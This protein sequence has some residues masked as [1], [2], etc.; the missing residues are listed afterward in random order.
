VTSYTFGDSAIAS[1]RLRIVAAV[2]APVA[3]AALAPV[4]A[5]AVRAVI[6]LGCGPG[7]TTLLLAEV[8]PAATVTGVDQSAAYIAE[9]RARGDARCRYEVG[10]V[11]HEPL[12]GAPADVVYAR[13][14]LSH[15][16]DVH[17]YVERWCRAL[18]PRGWLVLEEPEAITSTDRDFAAYERISASLVQATGAPFYAGPV[19]AAL[20]TPAGMERV[21]DEAVA[22]DV[23]AGQAAAMFWRNARAWDPTSVTRAGHAPA[24]VLQL[25][26]RLHA[27]ENDPTRGLFNW[28]QRQLVLRRHPG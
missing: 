21:R 10:D 17:A 24:A 26:E 7:H 19:L 13:Y 27:R 16:P 9:A 28:R 1:E 22:I 3:R 14:L 4:D 20:A 25:A 5:T 18:R 15:L 2:M 6:D 23:T 11:G 8:F 12:P